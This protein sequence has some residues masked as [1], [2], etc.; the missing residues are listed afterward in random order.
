MLSEYINA[1]MALA[2]ISLLEDSSEP[3]DSPEFIGEIPGLQGVWS[4]EPT[5]EACRTELQSVLESWILFRLTRGMSIPVLDGVD[6]SV[7][8]V[9]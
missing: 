3:D 5:P 4:S 1:A 7:A 8:T 2:Q 6:L 9:S